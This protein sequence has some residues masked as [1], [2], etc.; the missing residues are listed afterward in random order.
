MEALALRPCVSLSLQG[1]WPCFWGWYQEIPVSSLAGLAV[2][3]LPG[4][5]AAC[6]H[7]RPQPPPPPPASIGLPVPPAEEGRAVGQ[8]WQGLTIAGLHFCGG[9][10]CV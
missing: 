9:S 3:F 8:M 4:K 6:A 5:E 10:R 1:A 7:L 2:T